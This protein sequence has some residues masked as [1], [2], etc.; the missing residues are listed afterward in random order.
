M[1]REGL[2][3]EGARVQAV[4]LDVDVP[5]QGPV[6]LTPLDVQ[7]QISLRDETLHSYTVSHVQVRQERKWSDARRN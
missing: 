5:V 3:A 7:G 1:G 6:V 2:D 4:L